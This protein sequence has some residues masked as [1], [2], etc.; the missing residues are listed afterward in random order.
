MQAEGREDR[1]LAGKS[2]LAGWEY[3]ILALNECT[4]PS[5]EC[6]RSHASKSGRFAKFNGLVDLQE[7]V[8]DL[9]ASKRRDGKS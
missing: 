4:S 2:R 8:K 5:Y 9:K 6:C 7:D 3:E 1:G